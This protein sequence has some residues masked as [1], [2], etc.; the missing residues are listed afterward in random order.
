MIIKGDDK[1]PEAK[2]ISLSYNT[3]LLHLQVYHNMRHSTGEQWNHVSLCMLNSGGIRTAIDERY[4]N[5]SF[6][7]PLCRIAEF[8]IHLEVFCS[9][10]LFTFICCPF[11]LHNNGGDPHR[12]T[13]WRN[14]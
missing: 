8:L 9:L 14:L 2:R 7:F 5:G 11:R 10:L 4:R 3:S 13:I 1:Q 12:V 6:F